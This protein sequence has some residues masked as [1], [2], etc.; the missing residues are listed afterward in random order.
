[1]PRI[2]PSGLALTVACNASLQLQE[3]VAPLPPTDE[4]AE[5][6]AAHWVARRY[7]AGYG[8]ELPVGAKFHNEG[9]DWTV[10]ADMH[11]GAILYHNALG[12]CHTDL[13]VEEYVECK[14]VHYTEC[15]GTPDA[16]RFYHDARTAYAACPDGLPV[17]RFLAGRIKLLRVGDYK[18]G[19]RYV[20][21]FENF[22]LGAGYASGI[23]DKLGLHDIDEDL[24]VELILVQPRSFRREGPVRVWRLPAIELRHNVNDAHE[25]ADVALMP[26]GEPFA[27]KAKTGK[28]CL[29]CRARHVC[30]ALQT[31]TMSLVDYAHTAER[32]ELPPMALGQELAIVEDAITRLEARQSGLAAQAEAMIRAGG[33]VPFYG[34]A[35]GKSILQYL[36]DVN[37]DE[38]V[39]FGD[40]INVNLRR[41]QERKDL[42][43]TPTQAI[44]LGV[45]E[46]AMKAYAHR[47][48]GKLKLARINSVTVRKVFNK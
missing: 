16:F 22:Q 35:P 31:Q 11:A 2:R 25:A 47:P 10:D 30:M 1:M 24:Y 9:R 8:P 7:L 14:R 17:D 43:V 18:Y 36:D 21:V 20:E 29:D 44:Q 45:D 37:T 48:P 26:L 23:L 38:L 6:T 46:E 32:V 42:V 33:A 5:G 34:M 28:H 3:S 19:H 15:A 12:G 41:K 39:G 40:L 13:H 27:P 4:E